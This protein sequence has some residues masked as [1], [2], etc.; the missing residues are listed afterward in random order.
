MVSRHQ[1]STI[2]H[3]PSTIYH[4]PS[5]ILYQQYYYLQTNSTTIY[6]IRYFIFC[7]Y[8]QTSIDNNLAFVSFDSDPFFSFLLYNTQD[9]M[10]S[11]L[12]RTPVY[13]FCCLITQIIH[14]LIR[15]YF[16]YELGNYLLPCFKI[17]KLELG[18]KNEYFEILYFMVFYI[19][20]KW[21]MNI[22]LVQ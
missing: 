9:I 15:F 16:Q 5:T 13:L 6:N 4:Q 17:T 3:Q 19:I 14:F 2:H 7:I 8:I 12:F 18:I 11:F 22:Y 10:V 1:P 21:Y 20:G